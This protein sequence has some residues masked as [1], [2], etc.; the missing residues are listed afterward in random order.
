MSLQERLIK[1]L[2]NPTTAYSSRSIKH[3]DPALYSGGRDELEP[4]IIQLRTKLTL[5]QDHFDTENKKIFTP[6]AAWKDLP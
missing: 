6:P 4:F 2:S 1:S 5:N 3:P